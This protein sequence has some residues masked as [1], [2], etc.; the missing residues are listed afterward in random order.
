MS[1]I[2]GS[3]SGV[4]SAQVMADLK[5]GEIDRLVVLAAKPDALPEKLTGRKLFIVAQGRCELR[6]AAPTR[7]SRIL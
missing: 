5:P 1:L 4:A 2:G 3:F 7:H 6:R